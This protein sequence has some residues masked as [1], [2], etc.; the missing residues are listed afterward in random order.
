M[1]EAETSIKETLEIFKAFKAEDKIKEKLLCQLIEINTELLSTV[2]M[3]ELKKSEELL[4][5][6]HYF[7][8]LK[9]L[10]PQSSQKL[11]EICKESQT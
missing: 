6:N 3:L 4:Q 1:Q 11:I 7:L 5:L 9:L 8:S 10:I 2:M